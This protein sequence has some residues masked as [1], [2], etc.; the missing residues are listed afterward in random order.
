MARAAAT[1][2]AELA[3]RLRSEGGLSFTIGAVSERE[4]IPLAPISPGQILT[5]NVSPDI[6]ERSLSVKYP[7]VYVYCDRIANTLKE[8]FRTFSGTASLNVEIRVSHDH[9]DALS[10]QLQLYVDAITDVL[11]QSRGTWSSGTFY[12]GG[13]EVV[14]TPV[15]SGGKHFIQSAKVRFDVH[16]SA[17]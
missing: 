1:V 10:G 14:F 16:L 17:D 2:T 5:Q 6:V 11:D 13:Y 15:K 9:V 12:T 3:G 4:Q 7:L 8:K